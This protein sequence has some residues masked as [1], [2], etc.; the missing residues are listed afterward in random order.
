MNLLLS[1]LPD[2]KFHPSFIGYNGNMIDSQSKAAAMLV[3]ES[4]ATK[5]YLW[6][7]LAFIVVQLPGFCYRMYQL[8]TPERSSLQYVLYLLQAITQPAQGLFTCMLYNYNR[9]YTL[10]KNNEE[11]GDSPQLAPREMAALREQVTSI[12]EQVQ[13]LRFACESLPPSARTEVVSSIASLEAT[14]KILNSQIT[15]FEV[16]Q[17]W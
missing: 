4:R 11:T 8:Y 10:E 17:Q 2:H 16:G 15:I 5:H 12:E 13:L 7:L 3:L 9:R 14:K 6:Y 1:P